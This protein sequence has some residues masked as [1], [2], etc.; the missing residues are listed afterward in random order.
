MSALPTA[1]PLA[2]SASLYPPALLTL[3]LLLSAKHPRGLVLAY[4]AGAALLTVGAGLIALA[5]L[6]STWST[7]QASN[8]V[9]GWVDVAIGLA[10]LALAAWA[11]KRHARDPKPTA[12]PDSTS[13]GRLAVWS[14][15]A[16]TSQ[17]W[18]FALGL[19]MFL[20]SPTYLLGISDIAATSDSSSSK[21]TATL[22]CA[23]VVLLFLEV[24]VMGMFVRPATVTARIN[25]FHGWLVRN[26]WTLA[27]AAAL[28]AGIYAI[29]D[30]IGALS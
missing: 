3:I 5:A 18:A 20:P 1:L 17:K 19:A 8:T 23:V 29:A 26:G 10:L 28:I 24:T 27:S 14:R 30:G 9:S 12:K 6:Q 21:I 25:S 7:N 4:F 22:I 16:T 2:L 11:W 15:R 13:E